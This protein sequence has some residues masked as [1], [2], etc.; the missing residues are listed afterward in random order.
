MQCSPCLG[1][2]KVTV[3]DGDDSN[4]CGSGETMER[5]RE[6]ILRVG[7]FELSGVRRTKNP[8]DLDGL[9]KRA[10]GRLQHVLIRDLRIREI[11][12]WVSS[13]VR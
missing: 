8:F 12:R 9:L 11:V 2:G 1:S 5:K 13:K 6:T 3:I 10:I 4:E 7:G